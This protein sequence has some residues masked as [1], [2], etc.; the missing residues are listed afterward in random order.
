MGTTGN[1]TDRYKKLANAKA[2]S[3]RVVAA[4]TVSSNASY[5]SFLLNDATGLAGVAVLCRNACGSWSL[6]SQLPEQ[7]RL[8]RPTVMMS[9]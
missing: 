5:A 7:Q 4:L 1:N 8:R 6:S 2:Q 9:E 3:D